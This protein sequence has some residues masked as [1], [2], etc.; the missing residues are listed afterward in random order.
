MQI[1]QKEKRRP[2]ERCSIGWFTPQVATTVRAERIPST[3]QGAASSVGA[4]AQGRGAVLYC[5]LSTSTELNQKWSN[6]LTNWNPYASRLCK[7]TGCDPTS[8]A[9]GN[10]CIQIRN[11]L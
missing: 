10:V 7:Q 5:F 2:R 8:L 6:Q 11:F 3:E 4:G 1:L 9:L